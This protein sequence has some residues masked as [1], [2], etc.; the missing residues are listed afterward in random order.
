MPPCAT[1]A[2]TPIAGAATPTT[3]R[4]VGFQPGYLRVVR[5]TRKNRTGSS[6]M[7][8]ANSQLAADPGSLG[9]VVETYSVA[10]AMPYRSPSRAARSAAVSAPAARRDSASA[11][12][13][14]RFEYP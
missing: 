14:L 8:A 6:A 7:P 13:P 4:Y 5:I 2:P 10:G 1:V 12:S 11:A 3:Y 9:G